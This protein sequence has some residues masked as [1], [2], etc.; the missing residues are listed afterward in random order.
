MEK[1]IR[2]GGKGLIG[3]R[4]NNFLIDYFKWV[5]AL[6]VFLIL[7]SGTFFVI[8]PKYSLV[9]KKIEAANQTLKAKEIKLTQYL[10]NLNELNENFKAVSSDELSKINVILPDK[11]GVEDLYS[12]IEKLVKNNG[13]L[14]SSLNIPP[15]ET[16]SASEIAPDD[17][18]EAK[19]VRINL[20]VV[21]ADYTSFKNLLRTLENNLRLMDVESVTFSPK[22]KNVSLDFTTYYF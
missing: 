12:Q 3:S 20:N 2:K 18:R 16:V 17:N 19:K 11:P 9:E 1:I 5:I 14:I 10:K 4:L 15:I 6:T 7:A 8:L 13:L 21:G 22:E